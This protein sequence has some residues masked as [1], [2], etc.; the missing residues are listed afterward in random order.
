MSHLFDFLVQRL[1]FSDWTK[2]KKEKK[3]HCDC[4][5]SVSN[6][7]Y[8]LFR[9]HNNFSAHKLNHLCRFELFNNS[10][11]KPS[12]EKSGWMLTVA[13]S[14]K[15]PPNKKTSY[16]KWIKCCFRFSSGGKHYKDNLKLKSLSRFLSLSQQ[17]I[18]SI[19]TW[20]FSFVSLKTI[21]KVYLIQ[22]FFLLLY[23][24][25]SETWKKANERKIRHGFQ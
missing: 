24:L 22:F 18:R 19:W 21:L 7:F 23:I 5:I 16:F 20:F 15:I 17:Q 1:T 11:K 2:R 3:S 13:N 10:N 14:Y 6:R 8:F 12:E 25:W 9:I 4:D